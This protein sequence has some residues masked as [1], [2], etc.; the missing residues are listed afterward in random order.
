[1]SFFKKIKRTGKA[2]QDRESEFITMLGRQHGE[3][4][5]RR[6]PGSNDA[7]KPPY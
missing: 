7:R 5:L 4:G 6:T 1:M 3:K 2:S